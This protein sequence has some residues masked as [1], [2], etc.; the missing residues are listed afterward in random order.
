MSGGLIENCQTG[1]Y[2]PDFA[3]SNIVLTNKATIQSNQIGV[4]VRNG[5]RDGSG[6]TIQNYGMVLMDCAKML[7]NHFGIMGSNVLLQINAYA[8]SGTK[9]PAFVRSNHFRLQPSDTYTR[10]LFYIC[11]DATGY[12]ISSINASGNFW[13]GIDDQSINQW[14]LYN[15]ALDF[16]PP[17]GCYIASNPNNV[18]LIRDPVAPAELSTCPVQINT[19][20]PNG[21]EEFACTPPDE[22]EIEGKLHEQFYRGYRQYSIEAEDENSIDFTLSDAIFQPLSDI[23]QED[24]LTMT[25]KCRSFVYGSQAFVRSNEG[26]ERSGNNGQYRLSAYQADALRVLPN[27]SSNTVTILLPDKDCFLR[28]WDTYGKLIFETQSSGGTV[29]LDVIHWTV[30]VYWAEATGA[31]FR[32]KVKLVV[33]R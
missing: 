24:M 7:D 20:Y 8:N 3:R 10:R 26:G 9:D 14:R 13:E 21:D 18:E 2:V 32:E 11:Y 5:F 29:N 28:V 15:S 1:I 12:N 23:G 6:S 19:P 22:S 4:H 17:I 30:G 16:G 25:E 31:E 27:P 33:Q